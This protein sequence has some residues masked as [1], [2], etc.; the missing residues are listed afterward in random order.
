MSKQTQNLYIHAI[1]DG[2]V[3]RLKLSLWGYIQQ[4][5]VDGKERV[6]SF[7]CNFFERHP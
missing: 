6:C 4:Q 3:A 2:R 1:Q 7:L 5:V